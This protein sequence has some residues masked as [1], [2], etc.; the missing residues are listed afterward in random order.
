MTGAADLVIVGRIMTLAGETGFGHVGGIAIRGGRVVGTGRPAAIEGFVGPGTRRLDLA[1]HEVALPGLSDA[2]LHL[3]D[4]AMAAERVDLGDAATYAEGLEAIAAAHALLSDPQAWLEGLGWDAERWGGWPTGDDLDR[5]AP[6]RRAAL[7]A[8]DHH[9]YWV[10]PAALAAAGVTGTTADPPGGVIRRDGDRRPT[11]VLHEAA[12]RLVSSLVPTPTTEHLAAAI[13]RLGDRLVA[14]GVTAVHDPG[15]VR[16]DPDLAQGVAAYRVLAEAGRLPL[17]VHACLRQEGLDVAVSRG[18]RSGDPLG[19]AEGRARVGWMK[20][21]ADGT[22][23]SRT[24]AML[25]PFEPEPDRPAPPGGP[26]GVYVTPPERLTELVARGAR[27]GI[28]SQIHAIG[29][30]A[31]RTALDAL[32]PTVGRVPLMP[33]VEHA[34]LVSPEDVPRFGRSGVAASVQ[35]V[36]L[37]SDALTARRVW[38]GRAERD[39]Y[40]LGS[41]AATGAVLAFGTDAPVEPWDPWPGLEL[42]VTRHHAAWGDDPRPFGPSE[43]LDVARALRAICVDPARSAGELDRGRLT[44]GQRADMIVIEAAALAEPVLSGGPLG[45][46]RPRLVLLD[47]VSAY[48]G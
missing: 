13:E 39:A 8:H 27:A 31:V 38:G 14:T 10:S 3:A 41:L 43:A 28:A 34:Q 12:A 32:E 29:D 17:R 16:A 22:L 7:W 18:L 23:G 26:L 45:I 4:A 46:T 25:A 35:P 36:H 37:R 47:G 24:A 2:H 19:P 44:A 48:E 11:G 20:L 6:G 5:V 15:G 42:A 33:R 30:G 1:P 21:F 9:A 40:R